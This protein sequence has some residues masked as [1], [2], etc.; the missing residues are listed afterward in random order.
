MKN[1]SKIFVKFIFLF[2]I[3]YTFINRISASTE[4]IMELENV[5]SLCN[6]IKNN[7]LNIFVL[8]KNGSDKTKVCPDT[9]G[10]QTDC[11]KSSFYS[12]P[13]LIS[14]TNNEYYNAHVN[15]DIEDNPWTWFGLSSGTIKV[16]GNTIKKP[17]SRNYHYLK[18][19]N[20]NFQKDDN[21]KLVKIRSLN[22]GETLLIKKRL[23]QDIDI[24][25]YDDIRLV[26]EYGVNGNNDINIYSKDTLRTYLV[27]TDDNIQVN[28]KLEKQE[29]VDVYKIAETNI[30]K[31]RVTSENLANKSLTKLIRFV[32]I[33]PYEYY[34]IHL[35]ELRLFSIK[36]VGY[37]N[38]TYNNGI[39]TGN[40][41]DN[42]SE[43]EHSK[44]NNKVRHDIVNNM[45]DLS[46]IKWGMKSG[47]P[48]LHFFHAYNTYPMIFNYEQGVFSNKFY[49][50]NTDENNMDSDDTSS[51]ISKDV[52]QAL[53]GLPYVNNESANAT[54][55]T[56]IS[57]SNFYNGSYRYHLPT[58]YVDD[59][60][61]YRSK[62]ANEGGEYENE[63]VQKDESIGEDLY[64]YEGTT[65]NTSD[66]K[67]NEL[68]SNK[69]INNTFDY[70]LGSDCGKSTYTS[71]ALEL[72]IQNS[73]F[74]SGDY[75]SDASVRM[76]GNLSLTYKE[77]ESCLR[78]KANIDENT[79]FS[80]EI[81]N[82]Y[83]SNII[84]NKYTDQTIFKAYAE[85]YPGDIVSK[86]G[87]VRMI[88]G[89]TVVYCKEDDVF[90]NKYNSNPNFC[91][92][93]GG[94]DGQKSYVITTEISSNYKIENIAPSDAEFSNIF[95]NVTPEDDKDWKLTF[96][97]FNSDY[98]KGITDIDSLEA[99]SNVYSTFVINRKYTFNEL[100]YAKVDGPIEN[101]ACRDS[102][103]VDNNGK[104][105]KCTNEGRYTYLPFR[106]KI[107]DEIIDKDKYVKKDINVQAL[108]N[109][110]DLENSKTLKGLIISNYM[111]DGIKYTITNDSTTK[112]YVDWPR[113]RSYYSIFNDISSEVK[114]AISNIDYTKDYS[115][116]VSVHAGHNG[117]ET[118]DEDGFVELFEISK[119]LAT[120][121]ELNKTNISLE[122][123]SSETLS[124][125]ITPANTTDKSVTWSSSD[126]SVAS[127]DQSGKVS[128]LKSGTATI[129]ATTSNGKS[130]S[131]EVI[132]KT[133]NAPIFDYLPA[134]ISNENKIIYRLPLNMDITTFINDIINN[135]SVLIYDK[136]NKLKNTGV[137]FTGDKVKYIN[138]SSNEDYYDISIPGDV[139]GDGAISPL[140]YVKIKNHIMEENIIVENSYKLAADYNNDKEITPLD[141][142]GIKNYIMKGAN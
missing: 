66:E 40:T 86:K 62:I 112:T 103:G 17:E 35:G 29:L 93:H 37:K 134:T 26:F 1:I 30:V 89:R 64:L 25:E 87:H 140:D 49:Y 136:D 70:F 3:S 67:I 2:L 61:T 4:T 56:F 127:V 75:Y 68:K 5:D 59:A 98:T 41:T 122:K 137:L 65:I 125:T 85:L 34:K 76:L 50:K 27:D 58:K 73:L 71:E 42:T 126:S 51:Y 123:G 28:A 36:L 94:I 39:K 118:E 45:I 97:T 54:I 22:P 20:R 72:P 128:A 16:E 92:E 12:D 47:N 23:E 115:I 139:S 78:N 141:Y 57:R 60:E 18:I 108:S 105:L 135:E 111:I 15:S 130:S 138:S 129:T 24:S 21:N 7:K 119:I 44:F 90:T 10:T 142:V 121:I 55:N 133:T 100:L 74:N 79:Q 13:D 113:T 114:D 14:C 116:K 96:N 32:T 19:A 102:D 101:G 91:D 31:Y 77:V 95:R 117:Y 109:Y 46:T 106:Y 11:T 53:Y 38:E 81:F 8:N 110:S 84:K 9:T 88:S 107:M 80:N 43:E 131:C 104:Y 132:V 52:K 48:K 124:A 33:R 63:K 99:F 69:Y 120:K 83:Y 82:N 6:D